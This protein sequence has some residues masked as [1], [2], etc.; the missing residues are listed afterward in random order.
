MSAIFV[1]GLI[2]IE[3]TIQIESFPLVYTPVRYPFFGISSTVSGV[4]YNVAK[5]L[6]T[7]GDTVRFAA[8][9]GRDPAGELITGALAAAGVSGDFVLSD[10]E[11]TPQS[12]ILYDRDGQR[13]INVDLKDIQECTYP[14]DHFEQAIAG[15]GMAALCNINFSRPLLAETRRRG[16]PIAT[17]VHAIADLDDDYNRDFMA[18]ADILFMSHERLPCPPEEWAARVQARYGNAIVIVGLGQEGAL[19]AVR[20]DGFIG[21]FRAIVTRPVVNTIGAGDALFSAFIHFYHA[22][23]APYE[24]L[25]RA[26]T[27]ASYKIGAAG[28]AQGFLDAS[29][30]EALYAA[31]APTSA[32]L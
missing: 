13:Q 3:T 32:L 27:F 8:L 31:I 24:S 21:R 9:I 19:L 26:I 17:D 2:N 14:L 20:R 23:G 12:V 30:L 11:Q 22:S 18:A 5:A 7:L 15:C 1:S 16:I 25:R 6:T 28:A 29:A 10:L 4:G